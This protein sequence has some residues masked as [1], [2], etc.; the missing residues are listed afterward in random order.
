[1]SY[2]QGSFN[3]H[4][5]MHEAYK[6]IEALVWAGNELAGK[7][8]ICSDG[9]C[10]RCRLSAFRAQLETSVHVVIGRPGVLKGDVKND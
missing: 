1:M 8:M 10:N 4:M 2:E 5:T 3:I 7:H 6:L 9:T